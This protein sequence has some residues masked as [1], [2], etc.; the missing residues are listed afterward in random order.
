M[1][2][3]AL[4]A[5][6][7]GVSLAA[8]ANCMAYEAGDM[9]LRVGA[10]NVDPQTSNNTLVPGLDVDA[11]TQL[12][13]T[14]TYMLTD[15]LGLELLAATPFKHDITLNGAKVGDTKHLPP[16]LSLQYYPMDSSSAF[17]PYVGLG[18][19]YTAFFSENTTGALAGTKLQ[20]DS[21]WGLAGQIGVD[22]SLNDQWLLNAAVWKMDINT[23]VKV[24]GTNLGEIEID[25]MVYMVSVGYKF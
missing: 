10:A 24:D 21:S 13:I 16:T 5:L 14:G 20:L 22:Y 19:N 17:Q 2:R 3:K 6:V 8:T 12:G 11:N 9:I 4:S 15:N 23:D 25:P 1:N 7:L 18:I